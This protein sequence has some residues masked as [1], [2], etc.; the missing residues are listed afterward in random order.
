MSAQK[1]NLAAPP[2]SVRRA[3]LCVLLFPVAFCCA[4]C[5]LIAYIS[6][7][8]LLQN[9]FT[10]NWVSRAWKVCTRLLFSP[11]WFILLTQRQLFFSFLLDLSRNGGGTMRESALEWKSAA[12]CA[13]CHARFM[14]IM[15]RVGGVVNK[16]RH[17][18]FCLRRPHNLHFSS[19]LI[20][21]HGR[22]HAE[23]AHELFN[24]PALA[25]DANAILPFG[26]NL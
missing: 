2:P 1:W 11:F 10:Q 8:R 12:L 26:S 3:N 13:C 19:L 15:T 20:Q 18:H 9:P 7:A 22:K 16:R 23:S 14:E 25:A 24:R 21:H 4:G 17:F 5:M 6:R